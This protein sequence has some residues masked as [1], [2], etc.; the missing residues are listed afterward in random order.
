MSERTPDPFL[1]WVA[2]THTH[3]AWVRMAESN[4]EHSSRGGDGDQ[5]SPGAI[6]EVVHR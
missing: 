3:T 5:L 6:R 2:F 4:D 1:F